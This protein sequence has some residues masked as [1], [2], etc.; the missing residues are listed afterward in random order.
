MHIL[1]YILNFGGGLHTLY[2]HFIIEG[3]SH[4]P[5]LER[6]SEGN[7]FVTTAIVYT[8]SGCDD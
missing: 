7:T 4:C 8:T 1:F 6:R 2:I 3:L 5:M